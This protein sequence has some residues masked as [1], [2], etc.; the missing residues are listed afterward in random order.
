MRKNNCCVNFCV[1][2]VIFLDIV[3]GLVKFIETLINATKMEGGEIAVQLVAS[4]ILLV[5]GIFLLIGAIK[6]KPKFVYAHIVIMVTCLILA[7]IGFVIMI[8]I[9]ASSPNGA[10]LMLILAGVYIL[11]AGLE[12]TVYMFYKNMKHELVDVSKV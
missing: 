10:V 12:Y 1:G 5:S 4:F 2:M 7:V 8:F 11:R 3:G 9:L 6:R